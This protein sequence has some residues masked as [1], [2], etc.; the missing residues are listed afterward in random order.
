MGEAV[1]ILSEGMPLIFPTDTVWGLGVSVGHCESP[2]ALFDIKGRESGKPV[3][4]LVGSI[5]DIGRYG[6]NVPD[7]AKDLAEKHWP[8][9]LTIIVKASANVPEEF[10]SNEG[11]IGLRMPASETALDL[12]RSVGCPLAVT[13][14]NIS[15]GSAIPASQSFDFDAA[16]FDCPASVALCENDADASAIGNI[17][18][19]VVDCTGPFPVVLRNG[20][21]DI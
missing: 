20:P 4:W 5:D 21:V 19:T 6:S 9:A 12:I 2:K 16:G 7:Y 18:S 13:S 14:A 17:A 1:R 15:G 8:G 10:R 3:A 11:T